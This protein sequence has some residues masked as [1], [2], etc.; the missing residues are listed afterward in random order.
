[1]RQFYVLLIGILALACSPVSK[2]ALTKRFVSLEKKLQ[3]HTGFMLY[4]PAQ[5]K[6]L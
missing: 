3:D 6:E 4:D 5:K 1:M 2:Q